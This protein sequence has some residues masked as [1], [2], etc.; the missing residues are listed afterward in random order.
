MHASVTIN[1]RKF[2]F[3]RERG[4]ELAHRFQLPVNKL[5]E[6]L[7]PITF[8]PHNSLRVYTSTNCA[9]EIDALLI[10]NIRRFGNSFVQLGTALKIADALNISAIY[11]PEEDAASKML[12]Y[13][14]R[15]VINGI[16]VIFDS[17]ISGSCSILHGNFFY[18]SSL[19]T[20]FGVTDDLTGEIGSMA[21]VLS[22][23]DKGPLDK[24]ILV[25]HIRSGD[26]FSS[27][28]RFHKGYGQPPL[29]YYTK[30]I[31][32][33]L[34]EKVVLVFENKTNPVIDALEKWCAKNIID[35]EEVSGNLKDDI[36][37]LLQ[38][39]T[40]VASN[41]TFIP[42]ISCLSRHL[43]NLYLFHPLRKNFVYDFCNK[44][45]RKD[46][47][48]NVVYDRVGKYSSDILD[49]NWKNTDDQKALMLSYPE[50]NLGRCVLR[51]P[52]LSA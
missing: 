17:N 44:I 19:A 12:V 35:L 26:V 42:V 43:E 31:N 6:I 45:L 32:E 24:N 34:P 21:Q 8:L 39:K 20:W 9:E 38:A 1:N 36:E 27:Q 13:S 4:I 18:M 52:L 47:G 7:E 30:I 29:A 28:G 25:I 33:V 14:E 11:I 10:S 16:D 40:V 48:I 22:F 50:Q 15:S 37:Y 46:L 23:A 49:H 5:G 2:I 3:N 41:G 51:K